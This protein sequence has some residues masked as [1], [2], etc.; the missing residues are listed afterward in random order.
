[1]KSSTTRIICRQRFETKNCDEYS[2]QFTAQ[3]I[4]DC[5]PSWNLY[6]CVRGER[7]IMLPEWCVES[8]VPVGE[9][10]IVPLLMLKRYEYREDC[11]SANY[12]EIIFYPDDNSD[13]D[14]GGGCSPLSFPLKTDG[15]W[16]KGA[17]RANCLGGKYS[18]TMYESNN[19]E[20]NATRSL[21]DDATAQCPI[22]EESS[23]N[24]ATATLELFTHNC[25]KP[26]FFCKSMKAGI[27]KSS[28][29]V[30][31]ASMVVLIAISVVTIL[32]VSV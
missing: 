9:D 6:E 18:A 15:S 20:G 25:D 12:E 29:A 5:Q 31:R 23:P 10:F 8:N 13:D 19:C 28:S 3:D 21:F 27:G 17:G 2:I 4:N 24:N 16:T 7:M 32:F 14:N 11:G 26:K 30:P 1:M 22:E